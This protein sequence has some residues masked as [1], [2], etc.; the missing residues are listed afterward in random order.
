[1]QRPWAPVFL[2]SLAIGCGPSPAAAPAVDLAAERASVLAADKAWSEAFQASSD[3]VT[4]FLATV[5]EGA[6]LLAPDAP[7]AQ[8]KDAIRAVLESLVALPGFDVIWTASKGEVSAD[9]SLGYT[10]G[11]YQMKVPGPD[12]KLVRIDGKYLT[13][14]R[15][16][17][18]GSWKVT[19]DMFNASGPPTP[20]T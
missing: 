18:D 20:A 10:I 9:G 5:A 1:M 7:L 2:L 19:A 15:K 16:Q 12:G 6:D 8:G 14:W 3:K 4:T 11:S 13:A 17:A